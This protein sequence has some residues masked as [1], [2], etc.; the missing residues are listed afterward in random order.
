MFATHTC[1]G[2]DPGRLLILVRALEKT[3]RALEELLADSCS[4][5]DRLVVGFYVGT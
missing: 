5:V 4:S 2:T 1:E 3:R